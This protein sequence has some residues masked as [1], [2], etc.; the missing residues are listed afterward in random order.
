[1]TWPE[2][3]AA[4]AEV[5][6]A[7]HALM[8]RLQPIPRSLTGDG[9]RATLE[10]VGELLPIEV[11]EVPSGTPALDW[12]V[13]PEWN[14][15]EAW[16]RG[17]D[18]ARV[19]DFADSALH[20]V[21]YSVPVR[22]TFPLSEL[23]PHLHTLPDHPDWI[24]FRTTYYKQSWGFCLPH[25][26][27]E[28][29]PEG[30]YEVCIDATLAP[31]HLTYAECVI[32]GSSEDEVLLSCHSCHPTMANDNLS[33]IALAVALARE[34]LAA[35]SRRYTYRILFIPGTI[36]SITWLAQHEEAVG[37]IRHGLVLSGVGDPGDVTYKRSRRGD[38]DV[39]RAVALV[40]RDSGDPHGIQP[41]VPYGYDERQ[42]CS[43][44]FDLPVGCFG[45]TPFGRYPEYH[46][47]ADDLDFVRPDRLGDSFTKLRA[48]V[49]VLERDRTYRNL[50]PKGEPQLGRRGLYRGGGGTELPGYEMALLWVLNLSDGAHPLLDVAERSG[51]PFA[52]VARAAEDLVQAG[53]L[54]VSD[55]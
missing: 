10:R 45:R 54:A 13:P 4:G 26:V 2:P 12:T 7:M 50:S 28:A 38:A 21:G 52:A 9:F 46:T 15:R 47:S 16:I 32:P 43:P 51:V 49:D 44:G 3:G 33:G 23:R 14:V 35:P 30:D 29:L 55:A 24:P 37:R 22:G 25:R 20:L 39:D 40:L 11:H 41:F 36:G 31:G 1:M 48:V 18:G 27:L 34:L 5:G 17:P 6:E 53:L 19:V 8:G 42:Y